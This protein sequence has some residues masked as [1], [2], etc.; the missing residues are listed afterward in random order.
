MRLASRDSVEK[1]SDHNKSVIP[2]KTALN[3]DRKKRRGIIAEIIEEFL[4]VTGIRPPRK[5][6]V[7]V[8]ER[9]VSLARLQNRT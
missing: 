3:A 9:I 5:M 1:E 4:M 2:E 8:D 7:T 6:H